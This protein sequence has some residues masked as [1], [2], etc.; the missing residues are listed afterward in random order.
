MITLTLPDG[1]KREYAAGT[2]GLQVAQ[3]IGAGLAKAALAIE[4]DG[5]QR[6]LSR[7]IEASAKLRIITGDSPEGLELIRHDTAHIMAQ[8]VKQL[9]PDTQ[10]TIGPAIEDG[11]Y[12]DFARATPFST[13]D[14]EKIE[15]K[16]REITEKDIPFER[17]VWSRDEAVAFFKKQGEAYKAEIIASIPAN[18]DVTLYRQG[19]FIDLCRGPHAPSTGKIRHYKLMKV[20]G[21]YWRGDSKNAMLQRI[22]GTAWGSEK[23]LKEYLTRLEEAE[24]RDHRRLGREMGLF[25]IQEEAVGQVFWHN[26]GWTLYTALQDYIRRRLRST[27]YVEIK[28]P[29]ILDRVLWE[30]SGHWEKYRENMFTIEDEDKELCLKPMNCPG[31][32][33]VFNQSLKSYRELPLRLAEFG[34]CHRNESSGSMHGLMRVR[35]FVQ[36]DAHIFCTEE[37]ITSETIA[38]CELLRSVYQDLGFPDFHVKFSDR[39]E[40]RA[41]DDAIWDRAEGALKAACAAAG[42]ETELNPGEGAFYGPKL[43]FVLRDAIG[44]DWQCGTL[45]VDFVLPE[46][47]DANYVG[48]DAAKH[49]PV[50]LHRA[51]LGSFE[52]FI[53]VLIEHYAGKLPMWL[54]PKQ[55]AVCTITDEAMPYVREQ[56]L[57]ALDKQGVRW[58]LNMFGDDEKLEKNFEEGANQ[59]IDYLIRHHSTAKVPAIVVVGKREAEQ[60]TLGIRRLGSQQTVTLPLA[61]AVAQ[62]AQEATP[63]D[64]KR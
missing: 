62:L 44:R 15:A 37:Q 7:P 20:A 42:L 14:L 43:E 59:K 11:F 22:Y 35:G 2:T 50:M 24:K 61:E 9:Y 41:G 47:L 40:K 39:P 45:Q 21:A 16:M 17:E 23:Q 10:V 26:R 51:I 4:L 56:V 27:G 1:S 33:Q 8:A 38:F 13:E 6:D 5:E 48:T 63:P 57:P 46:R 49:R 32:V 64:L 29:M 54:A 12:Y 19:D 31:H 55:V 3:S 25:H 58:L 36:D 28:T 52:R 34:S 60:G 53:G 30:K 18:E